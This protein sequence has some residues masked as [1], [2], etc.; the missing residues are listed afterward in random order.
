MIHVHLPNNQSGVLSG[1]PVLYYVRLLLLPPQVESRLRADLGSRVSDTATLVVLLD[2]GGR[3][4]RW[5]DA[6]CVLLADELVE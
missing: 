5:L 6:E 1:P 2:L 4:G 3:T